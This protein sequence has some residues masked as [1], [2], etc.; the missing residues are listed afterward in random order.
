[1]QKGVPQLVGQ[2]S[3]SCR[4]PD[5]LQSK[6]V[7]ETIPLKTICNTKDSDLDTSTRNYHC[8]YYLQSGTTSGL[9]WAGERN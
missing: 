6:K 5:F 2:T 1:M 4:C 8:I 7:N 9:H 3:L